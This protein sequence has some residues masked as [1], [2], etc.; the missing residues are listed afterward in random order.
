M[1]VVYN[2]ELVTRVYNYVVEHGL[3]PAKCGATWLMLARELGTNDYSLRR[4]CK[5]HPELQEAIDRANAIFTECLPSRLTKSLVALATGARTKK[6]RKKYLPNGEDGEVVVELI[7]ETQE[8]PP[9]INALKYCLNNL[10]PEDW[11]DKH[12]ISADF[13]PVQ[14][15]VSDETAQTLKQIAGEQ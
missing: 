4:W 10:C 11:S 14:M 9:D 2:E 13:T 12:Q 5:E 7:E 15:V 1:R 3:H 8:L 6:V